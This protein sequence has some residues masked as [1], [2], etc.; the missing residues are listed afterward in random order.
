MNCSQKLDTDLMDPHNGQ[1]VTYQMD[2]RPSFELD[3]V[4]N[5]QVLGLRGQA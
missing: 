2:Q 3:G 4:T 5:F 1:V